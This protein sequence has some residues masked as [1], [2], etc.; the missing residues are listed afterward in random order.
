MKD[1]NVDF[2]LEAG[3]VWCPAESAVVRPGP[4]LCQWKLQRGAAA[5]LQLQLSVPAAAVM[6]TTHHMQHGHHV[7]QNMGAIV[8]NK[9]LD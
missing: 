2:D 5:V 8:I 1:I 4:G 6:A 7:L 9:H 3:C